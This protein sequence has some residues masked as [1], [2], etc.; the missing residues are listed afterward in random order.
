MLKI[1]WHHFFILLAVF[2]LV[3]IMISLQM[4]NSTM[5]SANRLIASAQTLRDQSREVL[6]TQQRIGQLAA[7]GNDLFA[8]PSG[9]G[10]ETLENRF[11]AARL[12]ARDA[13]DRLA[14]VMSRQGDLDALLWQRRVETLREQ[15]ADLE[16]HAE[17]LFDNFRPSAGVAG[18]AEADKATLL[19]AGETMSHMDRIQQNCSATLGML[20]QQIIGFQNDLLEQHKADLDDRYRYERY[21]IA[22]VVIILVGM[23]VFGRRL[24]LADKALLEERRR[25]QEERRE[26]LAAIGELCGSV[27]H[28]IR[29]PLAAIRSSAELAIQ[30]GKMDSDSH[31]R[32]RDI[33][34]EGRVLG[35]RVTGLLSMA[36]TNRENFEAIDL[37]DL[38]RRVAG[39]LAPEFSRRGVRLIED[40]GE[41]A[42]TV[43]GDRSLLEQA[44]IELLSNAME[45]SK[46]GGVV[47]IE[48][49]AIGMDGTAVMAIEDEGAGVPERIR[50]RVFDLF[51]TTKPGGTGMGLATVKRAA[52]LH[53]GDAILRESR[54]GGARFEVAL[55]L[56][57][58]GNGAMRG[59]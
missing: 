48:C 37:C 56:Q 34:S 17:R 24:H 2:D 40:I 45:Q 5:Q 39:E 59:A 8:G 53:G 42:L 12:N 20:S 21:L 25:V 41:K 54:T 7:P 10:F 26:R 58:A 33:L 22:L 55:P 9:P 57:A 4:H 28:G 43:E 18:R 6:M 51:F 44:A 19:A 38:T 30:L 52:R 1:R 29:N 36:R 14:D 16:Q 31:E 13:I 23:L 32:L 47:R 27:A 3:V 46:P 11:K 50:D 15:A 35:D 49:H